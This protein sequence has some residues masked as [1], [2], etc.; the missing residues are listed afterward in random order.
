M[1][2]ILFF[3]AL[4]LGMVSCQT[5]PEGLDVIVGGEQEVMLNVS[6]PESTR[7]ASST[8]FDFTNFE[9]NENYDLRFILEIAYNDHIYRDVKTSETTSA[10]FPVRLAP[11]REYTFTV[12]ADL[13]EEGSQADLHYNILDNAQDNVSALS[14]ITFKNWAPNVET[15][16][17]FCGRRKL[18]KNESVTN[19]GTITLTRPFAK[20]R[21][22]STDIADVR[23]FGIEPKSATVKYNTDLYTA[24]DA[25]KG[26]VVTTETVANKSHS[27]AYENVNAYDDAEGQFTVFADYIFV[28]EDGTV[29]FNLKVYADEAHDGLIKE[30][31]F[32]TAIPVEANKV[33]SIV[34]DILTEGGNVSITV[35]G[36]LGE[37]ETI[38][39]VDTVESLQEAINAIEDNKSGNIT[40]GGDINLDDLLGA[41]ILATRAEK[42]YGIQIP[43]NKTV[44]LDL[45]GNRIFQEKA[46]S[47]SYSMI[48]NAGNLTITGEGTIEF[49]NTAEGGSSAWGTYTIENRGKAVLIID[50]A[51][52]RHNGCVNGEVNRD[53]NI[54]IQN[55]QGK[56]VVN[57]GTIASTQFRSLRDFTAGGEIIIN[58]GTFLGQVWMQGLG[59]GSSNLTINGGNFSPVAGYDGSSVYITNNSNIVNIAVNG[60]M[61]NT[62]IGCYDAT[63]EGAKGCIT[64]GEFTT[65]AKENTNAS[66]VHSDYQ[67]VEGENGTWVVSM[68]PAVAKIGEVEY[69]SLNKAVAAVKDGETISL[70]ADELFT[71]NNYFDNGGWKDG[72]G[73][74]GDQS[75]TIDLGGYTVSQNGALNDYLLWFKNAGSK[76]NTITIKNGTLDAGTTAYCALCTASSHENELTINLEDITLTNNNSNGSTI[77]VR[78]GS[79]LNVKAGTKI[80]G[81]N[82]YLGIENWNATVN[83]FEGAE[84]YMNGTTSYNGCLIGVGG[85]G[86][87]NVYGG[88]GKGVSGGLI[89][90][91]S[92]GT[93][94]VSGGEWIANTDGTYANSNKSVLVAQSDKQYNAGAGNAVVNVTGGTFKGG[95]NCYGNAVGDAQINITGGNFNSYPASYVAEG[96]GATEDNGIWTVAKSYDIT[97]EG[98]TILTAPG[99]FWFANEVN[100]GANYFEGKT[101][102]LG[103][104]IDLNNAEWTPIGSAS[105]DHGFMG[106]FD[107][108]GKVIKNLNITNIAVD[109][110]GYAYAGL[111]GVTE[112]VDQDNQ[113]YIKNL[114]IENV[115]IDTNGHIVAAAIAYPYYTNLENIKVQGNVSIEGGDY[116]SGVLAYTRRCV[117]AKDIAIAA[118][119]GSV[120]EG[121][122]TIGGVISDIQTNGGLEANYSNFAASGL[123]IKGDRN[124]G[125]IAGIIGGQSL[126]GAKVENVTIVSNDIRKGILVGSLGNQSAIN[127]VVVNN[128]TGAHNYVGANWKD[129]SESS[130]TIDGVVYEYLANGQIKVNG[131]IIVADGVILNEAEEY[132]ISNAAGM[133]WFANEVNVN[134]NKFDGKIVKLGADINLENA[135]WTPV[136]Q[137][138]ATTFNGVFDGENYTISNLNVNSEA[139]T[140]AHYSSGLFGWVESHTAGRGHL[141]NVKINGAT[142]KGHHNCGA[143]VGYITQE[144]AL[145]ENCHVT[146]ANV[147][148]TKAN[149]DADGDKAGALI[150]N[151]TVATPIKGCTAADSTVSAGRDA[152]QVIGA[153]KEANVT[154]CSA[155]N[156]AVSANETSTGKNIRNEVIGRLL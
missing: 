119:A 71:E 113:N 114:V 11:G 110:D 32:N 151:A 65:A 140:G 152:G 133:F 52:I 115:N 148:C 28:P 31:S 99:M 9:S 19:I 6:L 2:K 135:A 40:L 116:T 78:A 46:C 98:Y 18:L 60:G 27:F 129:G 83:V 58:G 15:R 42:Q 10:T 101:I 35:D 80:I 103:A 74:A 4:M 136:G 90:M 95:Y 85:N 53:T 56:V 25:V 124:I 93:I 70:V 47:S 57:G 26:T 127:N 97:E 77:K 5:G 107:G 154:G 45:N 73:Y 75:F 66:L 20:V 137:T 149:D 142:I 122:A 16:D 147:T 131:S 109:A 121:S 79:T 24:F 13:V 29:Q 156:V 141:K 132:I 23:K 3:A 43:A 139:Q 68:K 105:K 94:N 96:F 108:N 72:L 144:T 81:K 117:D 34:G 76:A 7:S 61:F 69:T 130:V 59:N 12:W 1:K 150:G 64:G 37:K 54:A 86:V 67:F 106:N 82:S 41:G 155:T 30:N 33:T 146:G 134:K 36:A 14:N 22:V 55:Y 89:A 118:N 120:I 102:K 112:G 111:F 38:N 92:G 88:Y 91:T 62:K 17:A 143:L 44:V 104:D 128:V 87:I 123:T 8:G 153:G 51:T 125:G 49:T 48:Q 100:S 138:G 84:I 126:N 21:V 39:F 63:K 50:N 145:V